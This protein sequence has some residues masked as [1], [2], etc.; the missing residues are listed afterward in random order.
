MC[1]GEQF[2]PFPSAVVY[3]I[4]TFIDPSVK[5]YDPTTRTYVVGPVISRV[6]YQFAGIRK[7]AERNPGGV[8]FQPPPGTCTYCLCIVLLVLGLLLL[9]LLFW[10]LR[11]SRR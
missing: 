1:A 7:M 11:R 3:V 9:L 5:H 8:T 6:Y 10:F 2:D 4:A